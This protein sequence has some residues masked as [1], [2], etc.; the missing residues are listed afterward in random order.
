MSCRLPFEIASR[1]EL[2]RMIY[3]LAHDLVMTSVLNTREGCEV[4]TKDVKDSDNISTITSLAM[5]KAFEDEDKGRRF[6]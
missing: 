4:L 3:L 6:P 2:V 5:N 1:D